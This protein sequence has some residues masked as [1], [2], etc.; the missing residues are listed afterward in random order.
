V[1]QPTASPRA[2]HC[3][4]SKYNIFFHTLAHFYCKSHPVNRSTNQRLIRPCSFT[5]VLQ[6]KIKKH[7]PSHLVTGP[8]TL[9]PWSCQPRSTPLR[10]SFALS[11]RPLITPLLY[12]WIDDNIRFISIP[13]FYNDIDKQR[14]VHTATKPSA[15]R[16]GN[17]PLKVKSWQCLGTS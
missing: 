11:P 17:D 5:H 9:Y 8:R 12:G 15:V 13:K 2:P 3:I 6:K 4:S 14:T 10:E 7:T 1:P 16:K